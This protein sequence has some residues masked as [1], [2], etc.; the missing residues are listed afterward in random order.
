MNELNQNSSKELLLVNLMEIQNQLDDLEIQLTKMVISTCAQII[1]LQSNSITECEEKL[2]QIER[3]ILDC[4]D[5][6]TNKAIV[7]PF[8][9]KYS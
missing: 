9:L 5:K 2:A 6:K 4:K 8:Q 1:E 7:K 3:K